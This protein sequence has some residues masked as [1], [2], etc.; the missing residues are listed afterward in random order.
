MSDWLD[1]L[2]A[3]G[4][5]AGSPATPIDAGVAGRSHR[6]SGHELNGDEVNGSVLIT[7]IRTQ[8]SCPRDA[9]TR[10]LVTTDR[11]ID[12][13]GG[14]HLEY[15]AIALAREMLD[16]A[17][18]GYRIER[19]ALGA[20]LGQCCGG[21]AHLCFERIPRELPAWVKELAILRKRAEPC[22]L[23]SSNG[24][25]SIVTA[26]AS[27]GRR[28]D[29]VLQHRCVIHARSMLD[30]ADGPLVDW[31]ESVVY[32]RIDSPGFHMAL[33]GAGH[34]GRALVN[35]LAAVP[36]RIDWF[37]GREVEFPKSVPANVT[38]CL[39]EHLADEVWDLP[40]DTY[41]AIM[42]HSHKL[43]Q[44]IVEAAL[45]RDDLAWCGLIGSATKRTLFERRLAGR[46]MC[47]QA[48]ARLTC[49]IGVAGIDGKHPAEIAIAVAAEILQH[50]HGPASSWAA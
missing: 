35:V 22:V 15:R 33:F 47:P 30:D 7:V 13:I 21:V 46:G 45:Q 41:V 49:P 19:F 8:G 32:E 36:C 2:I 37:D 42:T 48:L 26:S 25:K 23:V 5:D 43:D 44:Q 3:V 39:G 18:S 20:R 31:Q 14:G 17:G 27:I 34:V 11:C 50:R 4:E 40:G 28:H 1:Q 9:G 10:M 6:L 24:D 12:T 38:P 29:T 16:D